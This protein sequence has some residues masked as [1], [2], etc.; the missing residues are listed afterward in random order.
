M[1]PFLYLTLTLSF[2]L[3]GFLLVGSGE[4]FS[5]LTFILGDSQAFLHMIILSIT[6]AQDNYYQETLSSNLYDYYDDKTNLLIVYL[7]VVILSSNES[8]GD[9]IVISSVWY[10]IQS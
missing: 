1:P 9:S 10:G 3:L 4:L 6:S 5:S 7:M 8:N 2:S